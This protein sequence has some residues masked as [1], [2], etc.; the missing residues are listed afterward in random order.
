MPAP[1]PRIGCPS[2][3][4]IIH[5][6]VSLRA[7]ENLTW[8][9]SIF[10]LNARDRS[11]FPFSSTSARHV[12]PKD[13][14]VKTGRPACLRAA[15]LLADCKVRARSGQ[16]VA[17]YRV[18]PKL[19]HDESAEASSQLR[20]DGKMPSQADMKEAFAKAQAFPAPEASEDAWWGHLE[21]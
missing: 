14:H 20:F 7:I 16:R 17:C 12:S 5:R 15:C 3:L 6:L 2:T 19:C 8:P 18:T 10:G 21:F 1:L 9:N 11:A 13:K 4:L